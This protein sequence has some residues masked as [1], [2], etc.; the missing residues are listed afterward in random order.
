MNFEDDQEPTTEETSPSTGRKPS[1][2]EVL[3]LGPAKT[4]AFELP[5]PSQRPDLLQT[6]DEEKSISSKPLTPYY[7]QKSIEDSLPEDKVAEVDVDPFDTSFVA[8]AAPGKT[9]LKLIESA[10]LTK[11]EP[12]LK[13][14]ISDHEFDPRSGTAE[15]DRARR[16]SDF[17]ATS[18]RPKTLKG[19]EP[20]ASLIEESEVTPKPNVFEV[21]EAAHRG[22]ESNRRQESLLDAEVEVDAK[23][24]T[25]RIE[26]RVSEE[27]TEISYVDPFDTSIATNLLPGKAELK[28]L[29]NE[30]SQLPEEIRQVRTN[31]IDLDRVSAR[32]ISI[33]DEDDFD[34]RAGEVTESKDFLCLDG[35]DSGDKVLTPLHNKEFI[36]DNVD[37]FDTSFAS[38]G[39]GKTE[40]KLLESEFVSK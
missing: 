5:T 16:Q 35:Q 13:H 14:S 12:R 30:L 24:L 19:I 28:L 38:I 33:D 26:S 29:E 34:P 22:I 11:Q 1:R 23:P 31:P 3:G 15:P 9:E 2:P 21:N 4:V 32:A 27:D 18:L 7:S 36:D 6:S 40:L 37:P 20:E 39:P 25:P 17:G 10:L 8:K